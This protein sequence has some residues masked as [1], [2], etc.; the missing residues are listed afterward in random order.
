MDDEEQEY[1]LLDYGDNLKQQ[2]PELGH[3]WR[4]TGR[5]WQCT[6]CLKQTRHRAVCK[7]ACNGLPNSIKHAVDW[8]QQ[9]GHAIACAG[10]TAAGFC[11]WCQ[12]CGAWAG[13]KAQ[14]L[15]GRCQQPTHWGRVVL[16]RV[17]KGQHPDP[18]TTERIDGI[19]TLKHVGQ[20]VFQSDSQEEKEG[21]VSKTEKN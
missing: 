10:T 20:K 1:G 11:M 3:T 16:Q 9:H 21:S 15:A 17:A 7:Q 14:K 12:N 19:I 2:L 5:T 4:W 18:M 13:H 8:A 6:G